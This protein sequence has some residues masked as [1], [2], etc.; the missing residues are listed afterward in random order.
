ML[1]RIALE[2]LREQRRARRWSVFFRLAFLAYLVALLGV[3]IAGREAAAPLPGGR[4]TALVE[5]KGEIAADGPASADS[6]VRGLR[7]AFEHERTA[8]VI[9]R[10][11]SPG[12][13]PVQ[14]GQIYDEIRRLREAHPDVPLYA[15]VTDIAA[16]GAYY[17]AAAADEIYADKASLVGSIGVLMDGFGFTEAMRKLGIE[18]RL[19][20]AGERK[21]FL[22]PFSPARPEDIAHMKRLLEQVHRQF[23]RAV[24]EGRG[25]RLKDDPRIFSGLIWTGEE[26]VRLGLVDGLGSAG[27][28]AR[29]VIG[30]ERIVDFTPKEDFLERLTERLGAAVARALTR[31]G[32]ATL[33]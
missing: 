5:L 23:I 11:N 7:A 4:Y 15:V 27:Y 2:G 28:V 19:L 21:G 13:S 9:L 22:D 32:A 8:G 3:L 29:E 16:S 14:A 30:A 6:I 18:R 1:E 33:R 10:I 24:R 20:T 12:G 17:V 25:D 26:A 31:L